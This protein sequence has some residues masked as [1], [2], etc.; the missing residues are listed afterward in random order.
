MAL[1]K[2]T[3]LL[4]V[5]ACRFMLF[6]VIS[7]LS[8]ILQGIPNINSCFL[9]VFLS[10]MI[11]LPPAS[12]LLH[13]FDKFFSKVFQVVRAYTTLVTKAVTFP[14]HVVM[15]VVL[16]GLLENI[17]RYFINHV[18]FTIPKITTTV[19]SKVYVQLLPWMKALQYIIRMSYLT[20][21]KVLVLQFVIGVALVCAPGL[22]PLFNLLATGSLYPGSLIRFQRCAK[23]DDGTACHAVFLE[24]SYSVWNLTRTAIF[25]M[26]CWTVNRPSWKP[27]KQDFSVI[28]ERCLALNKKAYSQLLLCAA[29]LPLLMNGH[30]LSQTVHNITC[31]ANLLLFLVT[32]N[33][34]HSR[35]ILMLYHALCT[36]TMNAQS[37]LVAV[38][39]MYR[40]LQTER[41]DYVATLLYI[42][43]LYLMLLV[44]A[45]SS[46]RVIN[47]VK[48]PELDII[49]QDR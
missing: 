7:L 8:S 32:L 22:E 42:T 2:L 18:R 21:R 26:L 30:C 5:F 9:T 47:K 13:P 16:F 34:Y 38:Y 11:P 20:T 45:D 19:K 49:S 4:M 33:G 24:F 43:E 36:I 10:C 14:Y 1:K 46:T 3:S 12:L 17:L 35:T 40:N 48:N 15:H 29:G 27:P 23:Y 28:M 37:V 41:N 39:N 44:L 6:L 31:T 25:I